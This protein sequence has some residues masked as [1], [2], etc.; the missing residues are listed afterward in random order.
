MASLSFEEQFLQSLPPEYRNNEALRESIRT[1]DSFAKFK[2]S[3]QKISRNDVAAWAQSGSGGNKSR[4]DA[5]PSKNQSEKSSNKS[6][7]P[8]SSTVSSKSSPAETMPATV[9]VAIQFKKTGNSFFVGKKFESAI[10][11]YT[12]GIETLQPWQSKFNG[13]APKKRL[14]EAEESTMVAILSN[15]AACLLK[16]SRFQKSVDDCTEVLNYVPKHIKALYRRSEG[17]RALS[18]YK[19]AK[20]DLV[21]LL[22]LEPNNK[23]AKNGLKELLNIIK[24]QKQQREN[25]KINASLS[26]GACIALVNLLNGSDN[27]SNTNNTESD[28]KTADGSDKH[29]VDMQQ[30][31]ALKSFSS[32]ISSMLSSIQNGIGNEFFTSG[33]DVVLLDLI[34]KNALDDNSID[35]RNNLL[36][37][38]AASVFKGFYSRLYLLMDEEVPVDGTPHFFG[39]EYLGLRSQFRALVKTSLTGNKHQLAKVRSF[40]KENQ[41][42]IS[43]MWVA[44]S[45]RETCSR[46][47]QKDTNG[48]FVHAF[49]SQ[50]LRSAFLKES[51]AL[52]DNMIKQGG[53]KQFLLDRVQV[54]LKQF[55]VVSALLA[56]PEE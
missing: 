36:P 54:R 13:G 37:R 7:E 22:Q 26:S 46:I 3:R 40:I 12:K 16:L 30:K 52:F 8:P 56:L 44:N 14:S 38:L 1:S 19:L 28:R 27:N 24:S 49:E 17:Y 23:S 55:A 53:L 41:R 20:Q 32:E 48:A 39:S 31:A 18:K 25:E 15:R 34:S 9:K 21:R 10:K 33:L 2:E 35:A 5:L 11:S 42:F 45:Y 29:S 6:Q 50:L 43:W 51:D 4:S 47:R